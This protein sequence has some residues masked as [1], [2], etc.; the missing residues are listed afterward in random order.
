MI[1]NP[2]VQ[3]VVCDDARKWLNQN[4]R[5]S[6]Y[7]A[8]DFAEDQDWYGFAFVLGSDGSPLS[9]SD[10]YISGHECEYIRELSN[11]EEAQKI[12]TEATGSYANTGAVFEEFAGCLAYDYTNEKAREAAEGIGNRLSSYGFLNEEDCGEREREAA[13]RYLKEAYGIEDEL[14]DEL[15]TELHSE[16]HGDTEVFCGNC[17]TIRTHED[18]PDAMASIG[19]HKCAECDEWLKTDAENVL[20]FD[21]AAAERTADCK[22]VPNFVAARKETGR[23]IEKW[24]LREILLGCDSCYGTRSERFWRS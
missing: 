24:E 7:E 6:V 12:L 11:A 1:E 5:Y 2:E 19:Y 4:Y 9:L 8:E 14:A 20:C 3:I 18:V 21:C 13:I 15:L 23:V 22:C 17:G 16:G 10:E